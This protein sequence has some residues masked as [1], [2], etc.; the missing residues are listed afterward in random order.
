MIMAGWTTQ[1]SVGIEVDT[2]PS[3]DPTPWYG[4]TIF[5]GSLAGALGVF[6]LGLFLKRRGARKKLRAN[7]TSLKKR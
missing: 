1:N 4:D 2:P 5:L 6:G 3:P 7:R